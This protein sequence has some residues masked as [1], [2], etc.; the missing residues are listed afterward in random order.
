[1]QAVKVVEHHC[2]GMSAAQQQEINGKIRPLIDL[3][4]PVRVLYCKFVFNEQHNKKLLNWVRGSNNKYITYT[5]RR[6]KDWLVELAKDEGKMKIQLPQ[7]ISMIGPLI[8]A[9]ITE[10]MRLL[11]YNRSVFDVLYKEIFDGNC[12]PPTF[13][14][15]PPTETSD[16]NTMETHQKM[17]ESIVN[18]LAKLQG[19]TTDKSRMRN[20]SQPQSGDPFE[21]LFS[22]ISGS[23]EPTGGNSAK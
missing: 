11:L 5:D 22:N 17:D 23:F 12:P 15:S 14:P 4:H 1:M 20:R 6:V 13:Y 8:V 21:T 9:P 18:L 7:N 10:M 3:N 16:T 2:S 19:P